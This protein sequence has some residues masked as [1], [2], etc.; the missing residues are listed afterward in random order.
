MNKKTN[1]LYHDLAWLWPMWGDVTGEYADFCEHTLKL[2][3]KYSK[4][5]IHTLLNMGCGGGKNAFNLKKYAEVTGIDIS[6]AMLDQAK[7]LNPDCTFLQED[8][9]YFSLGKEFDAVLVDDGISYITTGPDLYSVFKKAYEHLAG[10]GVMV[11]GP[12]TTKDTFNQ[13]A[14]HVSY[15]EP[16]QKP[17]NI[18]VVY[19]ENIYDPDPAD[20][21][22]EA[23]MV[24]LIREN[25]KLRVEQDLHILGLF[26]LAQWEKS[27]DKAGFEIHKERY[28]EGH[29][30]YVQFFCL[31]PE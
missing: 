20:D 15:A 1:R 25:G 4:R 19:I 26:S 18:E 3:K 14:T 24:Y 16:G 23:A 17:E 22:Y 9:R 7:K 11:V 6:P 28:V 5:D 10:G 12:D 13:N 27:L 30:E 8:M 31:K 2:I 21:S 29:Y